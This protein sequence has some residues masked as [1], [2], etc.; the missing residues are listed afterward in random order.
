MKD[1]V[2]FVGMDVH[3]KMIS[4]AIATEGQ[5]HQVRYYGKI[6]NTLTALDGLVRKISDPDGQLRFVYEAGPCGYVIYRHLTAKGFEC[7]V[8]APSLIPKKSGDRIKNDRR[9]ARNLARL[10][11]AGELTAVYVPNQQ[12]EAMRDLTRAREDALIVSR[13]AKQRL[14]SF[15]LRNGCDF[16]GK[17]RWSKA[18]FGW[19]SDLRMSHS[20]Q[21]VCLQEYIDAVQQALERVERLSDQLRTQISEWRMAPVVQ[22]LQACRGVSFIT[23]AT[24]VAEL[25]DL[26]RFKSPSTLMAYLGLTPS[27]YSSGDHCRRGSIT[28]AGNGHVRRVLVEA[29]WSYRFPARQSRYLLRRQHGLSEDVR[30]IAWRAQLRLSARYRRLCARGKR[31]QTVVTAVARELIGFLWAIWH[32]VPAKAQ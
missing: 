30:Q 31:V 12:D 28:K 23:A 26:Q 15:L 5:G 6:P 13:K 2:K 7:A 3:K 19:L 10:H 9:D 21:Q 11:R 8:V 20:A 22:A 16:P 24:F 27:E 18:F 4:V 32:R 25:G 17:T 1:I 14:N 29:A